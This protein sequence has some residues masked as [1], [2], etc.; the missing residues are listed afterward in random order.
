MYILNEKLFAERLLKEGFW[1]K[2]Q[3][4]YQVQALCRYYNKE[5]GQSLNESIN[6]IIKILESDDKLVLRYFKQGECEKFVRDC[7]NKSYPEYYKNNEWTIITNKEQEILNGIEDLELRKLVFVLL[8]LYRQN[9]Y[10]SVVID[11]CDLFKLAQSKIK[12]DRRYYEI[13]N[14]K[15]MGL[16]EMPDWKKTNLYE[17]RVKTKITNTF[18][19]P[20]AEKQFEEKD[21]KYKIKNTNDT[22]YKNGVVGQWIELSQSYEK[23]ECL[24]CGKFV[25]QNRNGGRKYCKECRSKRN[26]ERAL[27]INN[28]KKGIC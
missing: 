7:W 22:N 17:K 13:G 20:F 4:G 27:A 9:D 10:R 12:T 23:I 8:I 21:I 1:F 15:R 28:E 5:L 25:K 14:L 26:T 16:I 2:K 24:T 3:V 19:I 11:P 6:F 18:S